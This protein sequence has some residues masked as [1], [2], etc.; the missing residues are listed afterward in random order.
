MIVSLLKYQLIYLILNF[1]IREK[2]EHAILAK[3]FFKGF[4]SA[5]IIHFIPYSSRNAAFELYISKKLQGN[6]VQAK[7]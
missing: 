4:F 2:N 3:F 1:L 6:E 7:L 5:L